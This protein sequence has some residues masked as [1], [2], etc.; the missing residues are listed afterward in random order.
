MKSWVDDIMDKEFIYAETQNVYKFRPCTD[1][2]AEFNKDH[3]TIYWGKKTINYKKS[4][5]EQNFK[6]NRWYFKLDNDRLRWLRN[7]MREL[8]IDYTNYGT[9][10]SISNRNPAY[11]TASERDILNELRNSYPKFVK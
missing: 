5:V 10:L 9:L 7:V 4:T 2:D 3:V 8:P 11:Y 1:G 6:T